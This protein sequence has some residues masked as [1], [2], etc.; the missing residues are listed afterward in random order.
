LKRLGRLWL[1]ADSNDDN[2]AKNQLAA[3]T[4]ALALAAIVAKAAATATAAATAPTL[5]QL[6]A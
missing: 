3:L 1:R 5:G 6:S 2:D 4:V